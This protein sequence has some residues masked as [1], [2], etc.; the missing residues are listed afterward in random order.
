MS[1]DRHCGQVLVEGLIGH[2]LWRR[3]GLPYCVYAHGEEIGRRVAA[4]DQRPAVVRRGVGC[5]AA[6]RARR[7][8]D[9]EVAIQTLE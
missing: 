4:D 9:R 1:A 8:F 5:A 7:D 3:Y 6:L 2:L